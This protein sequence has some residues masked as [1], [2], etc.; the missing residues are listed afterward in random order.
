MGWHLF[1][2]LCLGTAGGCIAAAFGLPPDL[3]ALIGLIV[4]MAYWGVFLCWEEWF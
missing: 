2:S 4:F 3:S 1:F